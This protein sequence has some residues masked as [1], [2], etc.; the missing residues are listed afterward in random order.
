MTVVMHMIDERTP[1]DMLA[2]VALLRGPQDVVVSLGRP[3]DRAGVTV[4]A[5]A[6]LPMGSRLLGGWRMQDVAAAA[7]VVHAWSADALFAAQVV[8]RN[9]NLPL[10]YSLPACPHGAAD[11]SAVVDLACRGILVATAP[12]AASQESLRMA[13]APRE[14]VF[15][16][17]PP[18]APPQG[19]GQR[20]A[21]VRRELGLAQD[22]VLLACPDEMTRDSG[23]KFGP[24]VHA[25]LRQI[26]PNVRLLLWGD[27]PALATS[28]FFAE[29]TGYQD[30]IFLTGQRYGLYECL[31]A[32][33][34]AMLLREHDCGVQ[35]ALAALAVG[36]PIAAS[37]TPDL[38]EVLGDSAAYAACGEPKA[39]SAAVLKIISDRRHVRAGRI[40]PEH[41]PQAARARLEEVYEAVAQ[42]TL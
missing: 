9:R 38:K 3:R 24:W 2:Q 40:D 20:R 41:S 6:P 31:A 8:A 39:A 1:R 35:A 5:I 25:I 10:V 14:T 15:V 28:Q 18:V 32:A 19:L 4:D 26:L 33:D 16:L 27:G 30:E 21:E 12:T 29:S 13:G 34:V 23:S 37:A 42:K 11:R 22:D 36:V 7:A 17:P